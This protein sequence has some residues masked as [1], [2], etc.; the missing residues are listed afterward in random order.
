[1]RQFIFK[2]ILVLLPALILAIGVEVINRTHENTYS[3]KDGYIKEQGSGIYWLALGNSHAYYGINPAFFERAGYNLAMPGQSHEHDYRVLKHYIEFMPNLEV[4]F[5][6]FSFASFY[7]PEGTIEWRRPYYWFSMDLPADSL[8]DLSILNACMTCGLGFKPSVKPVKNL[9]LGKSN[10]ECT[11]LGMGNSQED[12]EE[13]ELIKQS[14]F[15]AQRHITKAG[16]FS[17]QMPNVKKIAELCASNQVELV[18]VRAPK[19][20]AYLEKLPL[21]KIDEMLSQMEAL[22]SEYP[23]VLIFDLV[24]DERFKVED[25]SDADHL[26]ESGAEK[27]TVFLSQFVTASLSHT[28]Q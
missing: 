1:M 24:G 3:F 11:E 17:S 18:L 26:A 10:V 19:H 28:G 2:T 4:V 12:L 22:A 14:E 15:A 9:I 16:D 8:S 7:R 20:K 13:E 5:L 27:F 23:N 6:N 25:F 21:D